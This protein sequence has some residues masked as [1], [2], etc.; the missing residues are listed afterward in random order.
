M[1]PCLPAPVMR[2]IFAKFTV[3]S[4]SFWP[5]I[6]FVFAESFAISAQLKHIFLALGLQALD[7]K[8]N[9]VRAWSNMGIGYANQ[10]IFFSSNFEP[11]SIYGVKNGV[12]P[13][14]TNH[15]CCA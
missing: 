11:Q 4:S 5:H 6:V 14:D 12:K 7:L 13:L 2:S 15:L 1:Y 3:C 10:V 8:P 9:Y